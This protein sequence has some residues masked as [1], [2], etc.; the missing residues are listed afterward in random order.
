MYFYWVKGQ[1]SVD[2]TDDRYE[3]FL[4]NPI[5]KEKSQSIVWVG[6]PELSEKIRQEIQNGCDLSPKSVLMAICVRQI[7]KE[8]ILQRA[9]QR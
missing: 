4:Q 8:M 3:G 7:L 5:T 1:V 9:F 6:T 2:D